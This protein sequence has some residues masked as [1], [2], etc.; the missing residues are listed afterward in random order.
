MLNTETKIVAGDAS[1]VYNAQKIEIIDGITEQRARDIIDEVMQ[2]TLQTELAIASDT[3][4]DR[5]LSF[6]GY[7]MQILTKQPQLRNNLTD[8][9]TLKSLYE[10]QQAAALCD[11]E[12]DIRLLAQLTRDRLQTAKDKCENLAIKEAIKIIPEIPRDALIGLNLMGI[13]INISYLDT[14]IE[15]S[16]Q[17]YCYC[18]SKTASNSFPRGDK[19]IENLEILKAVKTT[20]HNS[21]KPIAE[22]LCNKWDG[23]TCVG[24]KTDSPTFNQI[25]ASFESKPYLSSLFIPHQF[26]KGYHR[27]SITNLSDLGFLQLTTQDSNN[28][29]YSHPIS[30]SD[31][32]FLKNIINKYSND[33]STKI[34]VRDEFIEFI[35]SYDQIHEFINWYNALGECFK[36]TQI[37]HAINNAHYDNLG[38]KS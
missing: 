15:Q 8:P 12:S 2:K 18:I 26:N 13:L 10:A 38:L 22:L 1:N 28:N 11:D 35:K 16:I 25:M 14:N 27:L 5:I 33:D 36:L 32:D 17:N 4:R 6:I 9:A 31:M 19:W 29:T 37:G 21:W 7:L 23:V 3:M 24:I 30:Q 34:G 20:P